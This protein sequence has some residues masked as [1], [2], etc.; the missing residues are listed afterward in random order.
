[1]WG[2]KQIKQWDKY[3]MLTATGNWKREKRWVE[4]RVFRECICDCWNT[5]RVSSHNFGHTK[6]CGC[7]RKPWPWFNF[8]RWTHHKSGER[9]YRTRINMRLRCEN[10]K[11]KSY[12]RY[13]WRWIK[14]CPEWD[15]FENFY[16]D[17]WESYEVHVEQYWEKDTTIERIDVNWNY[18]K[19]NCRWATREEQYQNRRPQKRWHWYE[20]YWFT[21]Q[22]L[23]DKYH[24]WKWAIQWKLYHQCN[25]NI[26]ELIEKLEL[27]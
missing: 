20:E 1:M 7:F 25:W 4:T 6:S 8:E 5:T 16:A 19:E 21:L 2:G 3:W 14:V 23:A 11:D 10:P 18:C 13:W 26:E 9:I 22:D 24:L 15:K 17:M 12:S 27:D